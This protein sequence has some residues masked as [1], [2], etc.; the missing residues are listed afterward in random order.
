M[1]QIQV[2]ATIG[3][4]V[5]FMYDNEIKSD[6]VY[7]IQIYNN[8]CWYKFFKK[9]KVIYKFYRQNDDY[10]LRKEENIFLS[11][12]ELIESLNGLK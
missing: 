7:S 5:W 3:D 2:K 11:K 12:E 10:I 1:K 8:V 6:K 4:V 9:P